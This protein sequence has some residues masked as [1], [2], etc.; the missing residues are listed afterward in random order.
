VPAAKTDLDKRNPRGEMV[1]SFMESI[2][3]GEPVELPGGITVTWERIPDA[4]ANS[5]PRARE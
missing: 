1:T 2:S 4:E 5:L 3:T